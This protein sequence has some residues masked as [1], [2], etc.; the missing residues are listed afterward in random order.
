MAKRIV[1]HTSGTNFPGQQGSAMKRGSGVTANEVKP[2]GSQ[3]A[4]ERSGTG[5]VTADGGGDKGAGVS[6]RSTPE[7]QHGLRG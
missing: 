7:N 1:S 4:S 6:V 3:R 5:G 2:G